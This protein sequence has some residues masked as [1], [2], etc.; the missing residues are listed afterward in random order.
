MLT[1]KLQEIMK[2][3]EY[4]NLSFTPYHEY[5]FIF[6]QIQNHF[7]YRYSDSTCLINDE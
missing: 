1:Q 2:N 4:F 5:L 6:G 3:Y 7:V